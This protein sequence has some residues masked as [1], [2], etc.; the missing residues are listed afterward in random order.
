MSAAVIRIKNR[1][2]EIDIAGLVVLESC[3]SKHFFGRVELERKV[4]NLM[5][6]SVRIE[7]QPYN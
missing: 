5:S 4:L 6:G 2:L 1:A 3:S 7:V